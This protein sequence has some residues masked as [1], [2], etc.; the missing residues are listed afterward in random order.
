MYKLLI[1][2]LINATALPV[3]AKEIEKLSWLSGVWSQTKAGETVQESWLGPSGKMLVAVNLSTSA[4]GKAAFEY[5]RIVETP[6]G[7]SFF[8]SPGGAPA[9]EFKVKEISVA[10]FADGKQIS[11][12][13]VMFENMA[14]DFPQRVIYRLAPDGAL[15][16]RI[17]GMVAGKLE[18][19]DWRF[20]AAD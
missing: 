16:A 17:E 11:A 9:T 19:M 14:N 15:L 4:S 6:S 3:Q 12:Q 10:A 18:A 5:M 2:I 7:L 13:R 8:A 1:A 20:V